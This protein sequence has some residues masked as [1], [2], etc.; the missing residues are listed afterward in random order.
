MTIHQVTGRSG[1]R[2]F[3]DA[4]RVARA[5]DPSWTAPFSVETDKLFNAGKTP[6]NRINKPEFY[7]LMRGGQPVGRV[8]MLAHKAHL[9]AYNDNAAHFGFLEAVDDSAI[10]ALMDFAQEWA[11][12]KGFERLEGPYSAS[13]NHEIGLLVEGDSTPTTFKTNDAPPRYACTLEALGFKAVRDVIAAE[14]NPATSP[15]PQQAQQQLA[16]WPESHRLTLRPCNPLRLRE[17]VHITNNLYGDAWGNN[18]HALKPP[19]AEAHFIA[20]MMLPWIKPSWLNTVFWDE[21]PVGIISMIP[22]LN[23]AARGLD[24]RLLPFGWAKYASRLHVS[25]VSRARIALIGVARNYRGTTIGRMAAA[26]MMANALEQAARA[27]VETVEISWML[28][29]NKGVL[30]LVSSLP[31]KPTRRWRVYGKVV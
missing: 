9:E 5:G 21:K 18:W 7:V 2:V 30:N 23:D 11:R 3:A 4:A 13:V 24:G 1:A 20:R 29:D 26:K 28:D 8:M 10:I 12:E 19:E 27:G 31:A 15:Y 17:F 16:A 22:D 25:G 6:F 14:A